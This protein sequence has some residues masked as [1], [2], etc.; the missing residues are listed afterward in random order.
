MSDTMTNDNS[1]DQNAPAAKPS[2]T[3]SRITAATLIT[4]AAAAVSHLEGTEEGTPSRRTQMP[5]FEKSFNDLA[6]CAERNRQSDPEVSK[7]MDRLV[8]TYRHYMK[9]HEQ[10][11]KLVKGDQDA[12]KA[13]CAAGDKAL[14]QLDAD[15]SWAL[16]SF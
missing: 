10:A 7:I 12:F 16:T 3:M 11:E 1:S 9:A 6:S 13:A 8:G 2:V 15:M 5:A 14:E 4:L